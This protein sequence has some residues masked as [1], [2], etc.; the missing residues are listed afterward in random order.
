MCIAAG[1]LDSNRL[2]KET[3]PEYLHTRML[4]LPRSENR[5]RVCFSPVLHSVGVLCL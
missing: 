2:Y 5:K 1:V 4:V 3:L